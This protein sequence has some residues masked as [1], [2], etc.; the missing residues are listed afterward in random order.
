MGASSAAGVLGATGAIVALALG[1]PVWALG[2]IVLV[3]VGG[4]TLYALRARRGKQTETRRD[5]E[6]AST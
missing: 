1:G 5:D 6:R 3:L 4:A 2:W